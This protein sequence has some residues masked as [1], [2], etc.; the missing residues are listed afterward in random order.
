MNSGPFQDIN[1]LEDLALRAYAK[2]A[3]EFPERLWNG[4]LLAGQLDAGL[5]EF[6]R[7]RFTDA[8]DFETFT[9]HPDVEPLDAATGVYRLRPSTS[10]SYLRRLRRDDS[11]LRDLSKEILDHYPIAPRPV[12]ELTLLV[13]A[14]PQQA[15]K[16]FQTRYKEADEKF[17]LAR[18]E[19]LIAH[20]RERIF[21]FQEL[22]TDLEYCEDYLETRVQFGE[23]FYRTV[24]H[25][26]RDSLL[27]E[28]SGFIKSRKRLMNIHGRGG[29]GK[30]MFLR[31]L[32][33]RHLVP[34]GSDI[35]RPVARIDID[36]L[37]R[38][39]LIEQ[40][41]L[42]LLSIAAQLR[43][44]LPGR[45]FKDLMGPEEIA[46]RNRLHNRGP[47]L[48]ASDADTLQVTGIL[49][50]PVI[51]D[52]FCAVVGKRQVLVIIDTVEE[53]SLHYPAVL[54][55]LLGLIERVQKRC[56]EFKVILS[57]RY[58]V[59]DA[60]RPLIGMDDAQRADLSK[61]CGE[62]VQVAAFEA[63]EAEDFLINVRGLNRTQQPIAEIV[64]VSKGNPFT[65]AL[66]ADL[67]SS[68]ILDKEEVRTSNVQFAYLIERIIDRI[69]DDEVEESDTAEEAERKLVQSNL[70]WLLRY[71]AVSRRLTKDFA[72]NVVFPF[73]E[74]AARGKGKNDD[75]NNLKLAGPKYEGTAR[76][77]ARG[78][79]PFEKVWTA[80]QSYA[81]S[82]S[83]ISGSG[84][85]LQLQPEIIVPMRQL[86]T[87]NPERFPILRLLNEAAAKEFENQ[88]S[89][90]RVGEALS[91]ALL[92][93]LHA[94]GAAGIRWFDVYL[95]RCRAANDSLAAV[96]ELAESLFGDDYRDD[97]GKPIKYAKDE[98][99]IGNSALAAAALESV[100]ASAMQHVRNPELRQPNLRSNMESR[101]R[102]LTRYADTK[103]NPRFR[104][105]RFAAGVLGIAGN[106]PHMPIVEPEELED[107]N[108]KIFAALLL[109][110]TADS[111]TLASPSVE[112]ED[113]LH[114][115]RG[116]ALD[117]GRQQSER[118]KGTGD[119]PKPVFEPYFIQSEWIRLDL[120]SRNSEEAFK[121]Y[122]KA[123]DMALRAKANPTEI[124]GLMLKTGDLGY[125]L[126]HWNEIES[127][128]TR[129][130]ELPFPANEEATGWLI[131]LAI[132]QFD[133]DRAE[134]LAQ[135]SPTAL[136]AAK[137]EFLA[138]AASG[139]IRLEEA[140]DRYL[141]A[142][143]E[144]LK[145]G[146]SSGASM[147]LL[148]HA[149]FLLEA[150][151]SP[152]RSSRVL[153]P[154]AGSK[155][156]P[157]PI[158]E[159]EVNLLRMRQCAAMGQQTMARS[160]YANAR[161][162][163]EREPRLPREYDLIAIATLLA[164]NLGEASDESEFVAGIRT[165]TDG[166]RLAAMRPFYYG[167]PGAQCK[168][169]AESPEHLNIPKG[170]GQMGIWAAAALVFFRRDEEARMLLSGLNQGA[171]G[172]DL[173]AAINRVDS[174]LPSPSIDAFDYW[175]EECIDV[176]R[177]YPV[178]AAVLL[179]EHGER[180]VTV[181]DMKGAREAYTAAR[182]L[183]PAFPDDSF[184]R[185]RMTRLESTLD[186][187]RNTQAAVV[188]EIKT[189]GADKLLR[190]T[191]A[192]TIEADIVAEEIRLNWRPIELDRS[193]AAKRLLGYQIS[194]TLVRA[195]REA[196]LYP[197]EYARRIG[198]KSNAIMLW[199]ANYWL[200][201][202]GRTIEIPRNA[203]LR[204]E[205]GE[206]WFHPDFPSMGSED[207]S[208]DCPQ[209]AVSAAPWELVRR[210]SKRFYRTARG[211]PLTDTVRY[212]QRAVETMGLADADGTQSRYEQFA[213]TIN[214]PSGF[215]GAIRDQIPPRFP[216]RVL[217]LKANTE[218]QRQRR[219]SYG[220]SGIGLAELYEGQGL[221]VQSVS[222]NADS[223]R[224][225]E[226]SGDYPS[227]IH[228]SALMAE[229]YTP[230]EVLL[231][232][233][234]NSEPIR[235]DM[236]FRLFSRWPSSQLR[237][238]VILE[239]TDSPYDSGRA[240]LLRN[241]LATRIFAECTRGV[242]AI[243]PYPKESLSRTI[244]L[245]LA[246]L[247]RSNQAIGDLHVNLW[248]QVPNPAPALFSLDPDLP[249]WE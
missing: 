108:E 170:C 248:S 30:T 55:S 110:R 22:A 16:H 27:K 109:A 52:K 17:D 73:V 49:Q 46:L 71:G 115:A 70:R 11:K 224:R 189:F 44:Q 147:V 159:L 169:A 136:S 111:A 198:T 98:R 29:A 24:S 184:W 37:H 81:G 56:E 6:L 63:S 113:Y 131:R 149:R 36:F 78:Q 124:S 48:R 45:P 217:L 97:E 68:R 3:A 206:L 245:L 130:Q 91:Q 60:S 13:F 8:P 172:F 216:Q 103:D 61:A 83:W 225:F 194:K 151:G 18:C 230:R 174:R 209:A 175:I 28:V 210:G 177:H 80:L 42:V 134:S 148:K 107:S 150:V 32:I 23:D 34:E 64:H 160:L 86:L 166:V 9:K 94:E 121:G 96:R 191:E 168:G 21:L 143:S 233:G 123:L 218:V 190:P 237:P 226:A 178:Y 114:A 185:T 101:Y 118:P 69:P 51:E 235:I 219:E 201:F 222:L 242:L 215:R 133:L 120:R 93:R 72:R 195:A 204:K 76:W 142:R 171:A 50:Q 196:D 126:G 249:V 84:D 188:R 79:A 95:T 135:Q 122:A 208:I 202:T 35:R 99:L 221:S 234:E 199:F 154:L 173:R 90:D 146:Y 47:A 58:P 223:I 82:S 4:I 39:L 75:P 102:D 14:D 77:H 65:L 85:E 20:L 200:R 43:T 155:V 179:V 67:A 244:E 5:Y 62:G 197:P 92:H 119:T 162:L 238:F 31:W 15:R 192:I 66:F 40:P 220:A 153:E 104:L 165:A 57:G 164:E 1:S 163:I 212:L 128:A 116:V 141:S 176:G 158:V 214:G 140:E 203:R 137:Q 182:A 144:Y 25:L 19:A 7:G 26:K 156:F 12:D 2:R 236:I 33:A 88:A 54:A 112:F 193:G 241:A 205:L 186:E 232:T 106:L 10:E 227:V 89:G 139:R 125:P 187:S 161:Q 127:L 41:W 231:S 243:G 247:R 117:L 145:L 59:F 240:L 228:I 157:E 74:P 213:V 38:A 180:L 183:S 100:L 87:Q 53:L 138:D 167:L 246:E 181:H 211:V 229:T 132:D 105:A 239:A 129:V 207:V 152:L